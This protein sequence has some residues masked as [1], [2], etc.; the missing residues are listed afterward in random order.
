MAKLGDCEFPEIGLDESIELG[1]KIA[2]EFAG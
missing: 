1:K 2:R